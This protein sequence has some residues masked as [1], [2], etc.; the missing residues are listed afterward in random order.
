[1]KNSES[2]KIFG[3]RLKELRIS[4]KKTQQFMADLL[5]CSHSNYQKIEYG[6]INIPITSLIFLAGYFGVTTDYLLNIKEESVMLPERKRCTYADICDTSEEERYELIDGELY[7][8]SSPLMDHVSICTKLSHAIGRHLEGKT[9]R[10]YNAPVDVFL[11]NEPDDLFQNIEYVVEPDIIVV[12]DPK[13]RGRRGIYGP[14]K[15]VIEVL[16]DSTRSR[17]RVTKF[18]LYQQAGV[19][20]YWMVDPRNSTVTV[21]ALENET[22]F[23][24]ETYTK[25][26]ILHSAAFPDLS[27]ALREV[28]AEW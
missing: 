17:D 11:F 6:Q 23:P 18:N 25:D 26:E 28:F 3:A 27:I 20:E 13:Q 8:M 9:C 1:M 24:F 2:L 22:Y 5:D 7:M 12:C 4:E 15:L 19:A 10:V 21:F 14:P 16:S